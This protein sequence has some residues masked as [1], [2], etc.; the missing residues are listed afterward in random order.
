MGIS[1]REIIE[2]AFQSLIDAKVGNDSNWE[3][4]VNVVNLEKIVLLLAPT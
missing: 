3:N 2:T 4:A 1:Y